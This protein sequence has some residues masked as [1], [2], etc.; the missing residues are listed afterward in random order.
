[1]TR[2][3][4]IVSNEKFVKIRDEHGLV[5]HLGSRTKYR[6]EDLRRAIEQRQMMD[7]SVRVPEDLIIRSLP[8]NVELLE[9]IRERQQTGTDP[10]HPSVI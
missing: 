3:G 5:N 10:Q 6:E 9:L 2:G 4:F 8:L 1:M 7:N